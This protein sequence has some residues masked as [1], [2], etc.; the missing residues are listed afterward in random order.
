MTRV[1]FAAAVAV[2]AAAR[3]I[4]QAPP[5]PAGCD[6]VGPIRFVCGQAG[7]EDLVAVPNSPWLIASAYGADGGLHLIDTKAATSTRIF[8]SP[9][10]KEQFDQRTYGACPGPVTGPSRER[11]RTHGLFLKAAGNR[12]HT[13]Y[14]VYHGVRESVEVFELDARS[15]PPAI[16]WIGCAVAPDP[17]GLNAVVAL[18]DGGFAAT[19]FDARRPA[20]PGGRGG[21]FSPELLNGQNNGEVWEWHPTSGWAKVP[22]SEA[23]GANGLEISPDGKWYYV[24]QWGNRSFMRLSRG[25]NPP[26]RDEIPL[27]FRVDNIRWAPDGTLWVAGQ[28]GGAAGGARAGG[29]GGAPTQSSVIG[30]VDVKTMTYRQIIDYPTSPAVSFATVAVQ[31][32]DELWVGSSRGDRIARYPAAG[33]P[34]QP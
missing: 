13:L 7:P 33:V 5:P 34:P 10:A 27:G 32:G 1:L 31:V 23:A 6:P 3:V 20:P 24:A 21:G 17:I 18:P 4:A 28:G 15:S 16:T 25:Q 9:A 12:R 19:N 11:F 29:G 26:T 22:G 2:I 14:V 30:K 8:P